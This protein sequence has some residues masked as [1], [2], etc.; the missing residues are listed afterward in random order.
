[1]LI[2]LVGKPNVGKSTFFKAAT[3]A[4]VE[5][6]NYPFTTIDAN[7][8]A[9][10]VKTKCPETEIKT[11]CN[12][13]HGFC[14]EG[15]R[16]VPVKLIDV[17]GLVPEAHKGKGRGNEFLDDL[18]EADLLIH[19][20]DASGKTDAEGNATEN[21]D[22]AKDVE[23]LEEEI[24]MWIYGIL[25]K[26]WKKLCRKSKTTSL[27]KE[28]SEQLSGM[29]ILEDDVKEI[30][31]KLNLDDGGEWGEEELIS[32]SK[33]IRKK[34]KP[35]I[36]AANKS[37]LKESKKNIEELKKKFSELMIVECSA[38]SE[39]ALREAAKSRLIKYVPGETNF[40]IIGNLNE[41]QKRALKKIE[42]LM[43]EGPTGVQ[44][45]LDEAVFNFLNYI[46][47]YPVENEHKF[48]DSKGNVLPDAYLLPAGSTALDLAY[49]IHTDI[50]NAFIGAIDAKTGRK[51]GKESELKN[52]DVVKI[53]T[54]S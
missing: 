17:A 33:E 20:L 24:S 49:E 4:D 14:I 22:V 9:G 21:Y 48:C 13:N 23:F 16:F 38:D 19:I 12:P 27:V 1:M 5:I 30:I 47:V 15:Q 43:K 37:D 26:N 3:L 6:A 11:K 50:G 46:V 8:G 51:L 7:E 32:F 10:Y 29:K 44:K 31:K 28:I 42:N 53:L 34:S 18:A 25:K 54:R 39:L 40:E 2:G 45:I 35:I 52:G 36:I 41:E